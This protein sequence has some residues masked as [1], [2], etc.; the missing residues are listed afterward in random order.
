LRDSDSSRPDL[1]ILKTVWSIKKKEKLE[2]EK[3]K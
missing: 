2:R 1:Y 3:R